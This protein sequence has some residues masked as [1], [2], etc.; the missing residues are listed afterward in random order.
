MI[1]WEGGDMGMLDWL[2]GKREGDESAPLI[3]AI[4]PPNAPPPRVAA[5]S[6]PPAYTIKSAIEL[7]RT[8]P[9]DENPEL[10][11][12]VVRKTLRSTGVSV[13]EIIDSAKSR[14]S[15]LAASAAKERA[16]IEQLEQQIAARRTNI[17]GID[18]ELG[19]THGVRERLQQA[20]EGETKVRP[21]SAAVASFQ[22]EAAGGPPV[23]PSAGANA[24]AA[25]VPTSQWLEVPQ[26]SAPPVPKSV[27]P[28]L[29]K[30]PSA[31]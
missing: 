17:E 16:A 13:E 2:W 20:I 5:S 8:L 14:E 10:V 6:A 19:E 25:G 29:P 11:L 21:F 30:K 12:R 31:P 7:M 1:A 4:E 27:A 15:A 22:T 23:P 18:T 26:S 28:P 24:E 3:P 9:F